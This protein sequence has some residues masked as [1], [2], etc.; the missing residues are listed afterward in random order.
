MSINFLKDSLIV[1]SYMGDN[2]VSCSSEYLVTNEVVKERHVT[3][4]NGIPIG[5]ENRDLEVI[6]KIT[7]NNEEHLV[8]LIMKIVWEKFNDIIDTYRKNAKREQE[9][10]KRH[11]DDNV[12]VIDNNPNYVSRERKVKNNW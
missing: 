4:K 6:D 11:N 5:Y 3:K 8:N 7:I 12:L 10:L 1:D 9:M 2:M